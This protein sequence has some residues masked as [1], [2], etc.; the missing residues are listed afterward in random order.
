MTDD[1][2]SR[3]TLLCVTESTPPAQYTW[4][5]DKVEL[6]ANSGGLLMEGASLVFEEL[7]QSDAGEYTVVAHNPAG[8][9]T[10]KTVKVTV[11]KPPTEASRPTMGVAKVM[12][13][14]GPI[15][16][17]PAPKLQWFSDTD[18]IPGAT[19]SALSIDPAIKAR[20][21][22]VATNSAGSITIQAAEFPMGGHR[23][24]VKYLKER[25]A[26]NRSRPDD[27]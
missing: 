15:A 17:I 12:L 2:G 25:D 27:M 5:K 1:P 22:C 3:A 13:K 19:R 16:G 8:Q 6:A 11:N 10:S 21:T 23:G 20:Y 18:K 24:V 14:V 4:F 7:R 9:S 26:Y